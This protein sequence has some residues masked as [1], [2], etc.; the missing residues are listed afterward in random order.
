MPV[1][2]FLRRFRF[3]QYLGDILLVYD[4][5]SD[6]D[7][8]V[9]FPVVLLK[10]GTVLTMLKIGGIDY[11]NSSQATIEGVI[12]AVKSLLE[13][14]KP[15]VVVQTY[16]VRRH[17]GAAAHDWLPEELPQSPLLNYLTAGRRAFYRKLGDQTFESEIF[18]SLKINRHPAVSTSFKRLIAI[19][20]PAAI[21]K[22]EVN[23]SIGRLKERWYRCVR[24]H[25]ATWG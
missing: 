18:F 24:S 15:G 9:D 7:L 12:A 11:E 23:R 21:L 6:D 14:L 13:Q 16:L 5:Y 10:D 20:L 1:H 19:D 4:F 22:E 8:D 25:F 3:K 2:R 17:I